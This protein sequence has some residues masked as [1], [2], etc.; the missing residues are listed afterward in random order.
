MNNTKAHE[1]AAKLN[2][3]G[4]RFETNAGLSFDDLI[5]IM[6]ASTSYYKNRGDEDSQYSEQNASDHVDGDIIAYTFSDDSKII[7]VGPAWDV[8]EDNGW[9]IN[10]P[11]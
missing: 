7:L 10:L 4:T 2:D 1:F 3:D 5:G 9:G 11:E 8:Y 6:G